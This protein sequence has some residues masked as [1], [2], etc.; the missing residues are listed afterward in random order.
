MKTL[1]ATLGLAL[2]VYAFGMGVIISALK[3]LFFA[4]VCVLFYVYAIAGLVYHAFA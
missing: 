3:W 2:I 4:A 1:L